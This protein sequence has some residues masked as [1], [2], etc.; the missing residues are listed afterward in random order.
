MKTIF[1]GLGSRAR[2]G[3]DYAA[4][5]LKRT[6]DIERVAFADKL[7]EDLIPLFKNCNFD[8]KALLSNPTTK[9]M[10]RP[11]LV[12]Y[13]CTMR[14]FNPDI[15]VDR[16]LT[17][18]EFKHEITL[19][20]DVRFP[21]EYKRL[22]QLGGYYI[23]IISELPYAN[24]TEALY[25]PQMAEL[26]DYKVV[27]NFNGDFLTDLGELILQIKKNHDRPNYKN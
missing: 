3:K 21:N 24:E 16:A 15:W 13:G 10:V 7:K 5:N 8:F 14:K 27:N 20:T 6:I 1:I 23:E 12:E 19:I 2:I 17:G 4:E 25:S 11:L 22:K 18:R 26:A 9:E